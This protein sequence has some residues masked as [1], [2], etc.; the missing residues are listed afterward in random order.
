MVKLRDML[1][2]KGHAKERLVSYSEKVISASSSDKRKKISPSS[3]KICRNLLI[4]T[5]YDI[6]E[7]EVFLE[8]V[9]R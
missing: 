8:N 6:N 4:I 3:E 7:E 9:L 1:A 2:L 5:S